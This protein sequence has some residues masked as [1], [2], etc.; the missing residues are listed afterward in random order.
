MPKLTRRSVL[1]GSAAAAVGAMTVGFP[2]VA[3]AAAAGSAPAASAAA[4]GK[5]K[6]T[7]TIKDIKH[8][9]V[10]MQEN[11][12]FDHYYGTLKGVHG[13]S[14]PTA[15]TYP[16]G[17]TIFDQPDVGRTAGVLRPFRMDTTQYDAQDAG[18]L[19]HDW[20]TTHLAYSSGAWNRWTAAKSEQTMGYFTR[21]DIP[22][23][24]ALADA[25]TICDAYHCSIQGPTTPNRLYHWTGTIDPGGTKGGPAI[26]NPADYNPVYRWTTYPE[27]LQAA[28]V[29][30]RVFANKEIG[31]DGDHPWVGDYGDN[32]LWLFQA[33]H[34]A[35]ASS[36]PRKRDLADRAS[37]H[38]DWLPDSGQGENVSHVLAEFV[39]SCKTGT[40]PTVSWV[41]APYGYCEHPAARPVDGADYVN[42]VLQALWA[43]PT[44]WE[45]TAV[46]INFDENDGYFDH[47]V[48]P[49]PVAGTADEYVLGKPIGLGPR[50]PMTVVSPWS[51]GG[52]VN[53]Q[54]FDHTSVIRFL[55][56]ITGVKEPN[57]SDWRRSVCGDLTSCFDFTSFDPSIPSLPNVAA[58]IAQ[59]DTEEELPPVP[60][61][62][63]TPQAMPGSETA[64]PQRRSRKLPYQPNAN[65][66]VDRATA[67]VRTTISNTGSAAISFAAYP[68]V[69]LV[70]AGTPILV[71]PGGTGTWSWTGGLTD[72]RY[73]FSIYGPNGFLRHFAGKVVP[74]VQGDVGVPAVTAD[75]VV[76][77]T[78]VLRLHL[79]NAGRTQ[80]RFT[81][82]DQHWGHASR[83]VYVDHGKMVTVDW[84]T[85]DGNYDVVVTANTGTGFSYRFAGRI[86]S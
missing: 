30:W 14:D 47:L 18:D 26:S 25:F 27:R 13:F 85:T 8:V 71:K 29:N 44:L 37:V 16:N 42:T 82:A 12:S 9:V 34:D 38:T 40:L 4:A 39:A 61:P 78:T 32:P 3:D 33:Y 60:M 6:R 76:K 15:L 36:D 43:N 59:A 1:T 23:H 11:R 81:C 45:S 67:N 58:L 5:S 56:V 31:D 28:G 77:P 62:P 17:T 55:E 2:G 75:L 52:W 70:F 54:V 49:V 64:G 50:V 72:G 51:R 22:Y 35:L 66:A 68:N 65:V 7:G 24:Y 21:S 10:L 69:S 86:E 63:N 74:A 20:A 84:P 79:S 48:P 19:P 83:T 53:S 73:D 80:V 57:I 41:V 46:L